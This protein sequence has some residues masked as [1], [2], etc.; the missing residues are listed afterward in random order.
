MG[1]LTGHKRNHGA[2]GLL[3]MGLLH[4]FHLPKL[5]QET[6]ANAMGLLQRIYG[7]MNKNN[8]WLCCLMQLSFTWGYYTY[9][10]LPTEQ[11]KP[12]G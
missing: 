5:Y 8:H 7:A 4:V 3:S 6:V 2:Y 1:L 10:N 11:N 9:F 12:W